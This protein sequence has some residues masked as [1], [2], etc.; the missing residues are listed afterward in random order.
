MMIYVADL[1]GIRVYTNT[2]LVGRETIEVK[3]PYFKVWFMS[4]LKRTVIKVIETPIDK[5]I[6]LEKEDCFIIHPDFA[7]NL[8][9]AIYKRSKK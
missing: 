7:D 8:E 5:M 1:D 2:G 9:G 4:W 3:E 6:Y